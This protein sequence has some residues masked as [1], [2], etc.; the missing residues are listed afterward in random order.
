MEI[1]LVDVELDL[2]FERNSYNYPAIK[3]EIKIVAI[4]YSMCGSGIVVNAF[5]MVCSTMQYYVRVP[6]K[7]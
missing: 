5:G 1:L 2:I 7:R 3:M 4:V 6:S